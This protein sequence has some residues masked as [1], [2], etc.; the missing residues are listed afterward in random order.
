MGVAQ[1]IHLSTA[2]P[3]NPGPIQYRL[4]RVLCLGRDSM[5][6]ATLIK[7]NISLYMVFSSKV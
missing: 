3:D 4:L 1:Q 2:K 5:P 6:I 7:E